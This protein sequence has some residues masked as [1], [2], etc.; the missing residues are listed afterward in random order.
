MSDSYDEWNTV[1]RFI[2]NNVIFYPKAL[3]YNP[4]LY[5]TTQQLHLKQQKLHQSFN[6]V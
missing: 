2:D 3:K 4:L 1:G 6:Y 5:W